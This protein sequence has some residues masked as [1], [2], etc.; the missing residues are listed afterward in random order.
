MEKRLYRD[1]PRTVWDRQRFTQEEF[2]QA[3]LHDKPKE[4]FVQEYSEKQPLYIIVEYCSN[5]NIRWFS[6]A[7]ADKTPKETTIEHFHYLES[8]SLSGMYYNL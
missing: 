4:L 6:T 2:V 3:L 5:K 1:V 8:N 7:A